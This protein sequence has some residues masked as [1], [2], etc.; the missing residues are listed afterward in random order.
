MLLCAALALVA[1]L[2]AWRW[3][4]PYASSLVTIRGWD[5]DGIA[6]MGVLAELHNLTVAA[7][8]DWYVAYPLFHYLVLAVVYA[9]YLLGLLVTGQLRSPGG[10]YP[11]GFSDPVAS[12]A[13][14]NAIGHGVSVVMGCGSICAVFLL[15]RRLFG[16]RAGWTAAAIALFS[17]P[18]MFYA[19]TGNLDVPVLFWVLL[20]F[21]AIER[22]WTDGLTTRRALWCGTLAA[23]AVATK[24]QAYGL[25]VPP[26]FALC[27]RTLRRARGPAPQPPGSTPMRRVLALVGAGVVVFAVAGGVVV[28][29]DRFVRHVQYIRGFERTFANVRHLTDLTT[30]RDATLGGAVELGGDFLSALA[31]AV[32]WP[33][34]VVG[35]AGLV[36]CW[37]GTSSVRWLAAS[38]IGFGALV[39]WPVHF[40]QYRY[41]LA[42]AFVVAILAAGALSRL[43]ARG[44]STRVIADVGAVGLVLCS[45]VGGAEVTH[46]M[47]TDARRDAST[48]M[49]SH[50]TAGDTVGF[51][52]RPHQLPDVPAGVHAEMMGVDTDAAAD[53]QRIR[54]RWIVVAPDYFADPTMERSI[55]LPTSVYVGLQDGSLGWRRAQRFHS[56]SLL[57]R[58]L[59]Y[60]PYVNPVVQLFER[61]P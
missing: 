49:A 44:S 50:L 43:A 45:T 15:S 28:R 2:P 42:P 4:L 10:A 37:R 12:I 9:P 54:P 39:I 55:F 41:A 29:P 35:V 3:G 25:L 21:V 60:L 32:S 56:P 8:D 51:F 26:L 47:L 27:V 59:P 38:V 7:R 17:A 48:W 14:L 36:V 1:L 6:G 52:G 53:L 23:L 18:F 16:A 11:F 5:V 46:A 33:V 57:G 30:M 40:M 20:S 13:T 19:R 31:A 24:D 34:L 61:Q 58:P 22:A